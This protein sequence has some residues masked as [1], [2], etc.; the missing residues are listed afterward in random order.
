MQKKLSVNA[1]ENGTVI[2]HIPT[3]QAIAMVRLLKLAN[4]Q[5]QVTIGINLK[6]GSRD[7]KDL[8]KI[9]GYHFGER[10][11]QYIALFAPKATINLIKDFAVVDKQSVQRPE[12][13][14]GLFSCPNLQCITHSE[15]V[16]TLFEHQQQG[17][18]TKLHCHYCE[19][20]FSY[21]TIQDYQR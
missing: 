12:A 3:G 2:D 4:H 11:A 10:E 15:S 13:I 21:K 1:I 6:S 16:V 20:S 9:E 8:I 5:N 14:R 19:K 17:A 7:L 18:S